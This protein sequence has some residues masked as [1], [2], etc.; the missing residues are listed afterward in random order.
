ML[1]GANVYPGSLLAL[2]GRVVACYYDNMLRWLRFDSTLA[3]ELLLLFVAAPVLYFPDWFPSWAPYVA[4]GVL[5]ATWVW[6]RIR[7]GKWYERTPV[8]WPFFFL[9][10]VMLP[11][12]LWAAPAPLREEFSIPRAYILL[13][14]FCL[15]WTIVSHASRS[16]TMAEWALGGFVLSALLIALV[17]PLGISWLYKFSGFR[18]AIE[19]A[20][21]PLVGV[22]AGAEGGF[23]PNQVAGTLL[24]ALPLMLSI[25]GADIVYRR[26]TLYSRPLTWLVWGAT[27][28][29][30]LI[31]L[32]TQSRS[33]LIGLAL[34]IA[35]MALINWRLGRWILL[36]GSAVFLLSL[37]FA[38]A[39]LVDVI[40]GTPPAQALGG[41]ATLGFRQDVWTQAITAL[42]D[43]PFTGMGFGAFREIVFLLYPTSIAPDYNVG[44]AHN[45]FLQAGLDFGLPG[46]IAIVAVHMIALA[47]IMTI[48]RAGGSNN[49]PTGMRVVATG[50]LGSMVAHLFYSQLDAVAMGAKT[51]FMYWYYLALV[52]ALG[53]LVT[54]RVDPKHA[55][56]QE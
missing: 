24:Y 41:T 49:Q 22:F 5:A 53:N 34:A 40:G 9:F 14:D 15:F 56:N 44:H 50:L 30:G 42:H 35:V 18:S 3:L 55:T 2:R 32:L 45:F 6:R 25:S 43:F 17:A 52:F 38:P 8:D 36:F 16:Y 31:L 33:A 10:M 47:Q 11:V 19:L 51:N 7:M 28:L 37:P 27:P 48:W 29:V 54:R 13:W 46:L 1:F 21:R 23:H 39:R 4:L 20:P 12:S 26:R